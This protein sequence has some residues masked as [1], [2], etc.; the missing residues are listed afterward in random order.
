MRLPQTVGLSAILLVLGS[1][2]GLAQT[3]APATSA[4]DTSAPA[5]SGPEAKGIAK[6]CSQQGT[7]KGLHGKERRKFRAD[8]KKTGGKPS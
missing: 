1:G 3:P 8:C 4:P 2:I 6:E 7:S 5:A